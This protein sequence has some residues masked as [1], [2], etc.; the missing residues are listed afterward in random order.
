MA[1]E[2]DWVLAHEVV[3][4]ERPAPNKHVDGI[5]RRCTTVMIDSWYRKIFYR[6]GF[7]SNK[8]DKHTLGFYSWIVAY[9]TLSRVFFNAKEM[10]NRLR[11]RVRVRTSPA[12]ADSVSR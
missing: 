3:S 6:R 10:G 11:N 12:T 1:G 9:A 2:V 4:G 5:C 8:L 7:P